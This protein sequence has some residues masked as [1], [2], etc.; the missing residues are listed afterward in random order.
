MQQVQ[1]NQA[2]Y[3]KEEHQIFNSL[4]NAF[5]NSELSLAYKLQAFPVWIRR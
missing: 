4:F 3:R 5:E 2:L 1:H